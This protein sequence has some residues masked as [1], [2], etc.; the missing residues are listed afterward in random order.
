[1]SAA[2][3][4]VM[5]S[6]R[7]APL[8][9]PA[10]SLRGIAR[11]PI[12]GVAGARLDNNT[13]NV[14]K[15]GEVTSRD[16]RHALRF[17]LSRESKLNRVASCGRRR[18]RVEPVPLWK[19]EA[20]DAYL[21]NVQMCGSV[22]SC[23]VCAAKIRQRRAVEIDRVV[24]AHMDAGGSA[25]FQT[26]TLPHDFG[27]SLSSL[28][29]TV[30]GA[31]RKVISG[32]R[33]LD[34]KRVYS[35]TASIRASETTFGKAGAHP[36]LHVIFF[37]DRPLSNAEARALN[38]RLFARWVVAVEAV[39]YRAPL[40]GLCPIE[41]VTT[42]SL[43]AYVQKFVMTA[44]SNQKLGMEMTRHDL[45]V[46]RREGRTPFQVLAD[47]AATGDCADLALWHEW[48][49]GS[50]GMQSVTW[51]KGLKARYGIVEKTDEELAAEEVGGELIAELSVDQWNLVKAEPLGTLRVLQIAER[52]GADGVFRWL[53]EADLRRQRRLADCV[54]SGNT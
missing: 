4:P 49:K 16:R 26:F 30:A 48:E 46:G 34:D 1:M 22:H 11:S 29:K 17:V 35:I 50:K 14:S 3:M 39:G 47:F 54:K 7:D 53:L 12:A 40:I 28:L 42:S 21:S 52:E 5:R 8:R 9:F 19:R 20:G 33:Y 37:C 23:P 27:D 45:K 51:S 13:K 10:R 31:F 44:D 25:L 36:H 18:I 43:G 24:K 38:A 32:S 15:P 2:T 41:R 6:L